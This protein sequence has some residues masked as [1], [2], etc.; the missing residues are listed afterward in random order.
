MRLVAVTLTFA[1][2]SLGF[3]PAP[4]P[5]AERPARESAQRMQERILR[6]CQQRLD[7]LGVKWKFGQRGEW[8]TVN[9]NV[10]H[11]SGNSAMGGEFLAYDGDVAR[12]LRRV[13]VRVEEFLGHAR[14]L[15]P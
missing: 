8:R 15:K 5:K 12:A 13:V 1:L 11:P 4:F 9:F 14:R 10:V 7:E 3:A 6:E 2:L